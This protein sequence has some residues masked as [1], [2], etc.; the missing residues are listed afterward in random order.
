M[1]TKYLRCLFSFVTHWP[2]L[3]FPILSPVVLCS[4]PSSMPKT[5]KVRLDAFH[6]SASL[7][8]LG[9]TVSHLGRHKAKMFYKNQMFLYFVT[10]V[11]SPF[12]LLLG[13]LVVCIFVNYPRNLQ[14]VQSWTSPRGHRDTYFKNFRWSW[15]FLLV[16]F[17]HLGSR[18][19][20]SVKTWVDIASPVILAENIQKSAQTHRSWRE[21]Q[22]L[23][24]NSLNIS[25]FNSRFQQ[26]LISIKET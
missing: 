7:L 15:G 9:R 10:F 24:L 12:S 18:V 25:T 4:G 14:A 16:I 8:L 1:R 22:I 3:T 17:L 19:S 23:F 13:T 5:A 26:A 20:M 21:S 6:I 11:R 2:R